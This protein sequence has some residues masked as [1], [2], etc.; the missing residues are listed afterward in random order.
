MRGVILDTFPEFTF[1]GNNI[2][3][4]IGFIEFLSRIVATGVLHLRLY[5]QYI[6]GDRQA[7]IAI[8]SGNKIAIVGIG[9]QPD[10]N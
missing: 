9:R 3:L 10:T 7:V 8:Q 1:V 6:T 5:C 2:S 4:Y